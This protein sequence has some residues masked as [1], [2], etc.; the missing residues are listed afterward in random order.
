M[1]SLCQ[2]EKPESKISNVKN[3]C[4]ALSHVVLIRI[5]DLNVEF[6]EVILGSLRLLHHRNESFDLREN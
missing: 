5:C 3:S 4:G 6:V 2:E 1:V